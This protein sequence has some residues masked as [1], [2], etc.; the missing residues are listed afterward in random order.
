MTRSSS[1]RFSLAAG[2][3][4]VLVAAAALLPSATRADQSAKSSAADAPVL[5]AVMGKEI[6]DVAKAS[7]KATFEGKTYYFCCGGCD[8]KFKAEPAKFS[9]LTDLRVMKIRL[10]RELDA[11]NALLAEV[12]AGGEKK[13]QTAPK[14]AAAVTTAALHCAITDETIASAEAAAGKAEHGGKTYYFCCGGCVTK[15]NADPAKYA[16]DA[17][18]RAAKRAN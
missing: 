16:A 7:G 6:K 18:A 3:A 14:P 5:C 11:V 15:F 17:N 1:L 2:T 13:A 4:A 10:Q 9:K 12:E 8:A